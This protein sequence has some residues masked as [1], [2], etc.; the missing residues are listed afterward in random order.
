MAKPLGGR[1]TAAHLVSCVLC[2]FVLSFVLCG[3]P[4][5][6]LGFLTLTINLGDCLSP[7]S[8]EMLHINNS[9]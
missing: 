6:G 4:I 1:V 5:S 9:V 8:Q 7:Y 3:E 2:F